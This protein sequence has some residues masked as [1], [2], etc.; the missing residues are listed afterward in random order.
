MDSKH[1]AQQARACQARR[2]REPPPPQMPSLRN[3]S[4][5]CFPHRQQPR[6][7]LGARTHRLKHCPL[8]RLLASSP[9]PDT[10][11]ASTRSTPQPGSLSDGTRHCAVCTTLRALNPCRGPGPGPGTRCCPRQRHTGGCVTPT[12]PDESD[13]LAGTNAGLNAGWHTY[14]APGTHGAVGCCNRMWPGAGNSW[15]CGSRANSSGE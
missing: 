13:A 3:T 14:P 12:V 7:S 9:N 4:A 15:P 5:P 1:F 2:K 10:G 6:D 11:R 8:G